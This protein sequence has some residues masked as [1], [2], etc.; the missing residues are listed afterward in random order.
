[1]ILSSASRAVS[2]SVRFKK[3]MLEFI[4]RASKIHFSEWS[5]CNT[6]A[7]RHV[8]SECKCLDVSY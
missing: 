2:C 6:L 5:L 8:K 3:E 1:M 4:L 7:T